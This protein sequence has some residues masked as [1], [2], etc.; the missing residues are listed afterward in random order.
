MHL[1]M[2][3]WSPKQNFSVYLE[4]NYQT[5]SVLHQRQGILKIEKAHVSL[6]DTHFTSL[7]FVFS[8][9]TLWV[10]LENYAMHYA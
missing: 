1:I 9:D 10:S 3:T 5:E 4:C 8:C 2:L 6:F 7:Y